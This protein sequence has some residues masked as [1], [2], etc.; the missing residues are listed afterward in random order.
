MR[1]H[2]NEQY[3]AAPTPPESRNTW[4]IADRV[5]RI[6]CPSAAQLIE[7]PPNRFLGSVPTGKATETPLQ[8]SLKGTFD[9]ALTF[10]LGLLESNQDVRAA[11]AD[12]L[13][14]LNTLLPDIHG[15]LSGT[16]EQ[17]NRAALG[18][19]GAIDGINIPTIV[20]PFE[21]ADARVYATQSIFNLSEIKRWKSAVAAEEA[22]HYSNRNARELVI[23]LAGSA[24]L[25]VIWAGRRKWLVRQP[26]RPGR[27][28]ARRASPSP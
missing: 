1:R 5:D 22:S 15:Q 24:Y 28:P 16:R 12:R 7:Q 18:F 19:K 11:K 25:T 14:R 13:R 4:S 26:A 8:L 27:R 23:L 21:V 17:L 2:G 6:P 20:G 9:R 3:G 10:N